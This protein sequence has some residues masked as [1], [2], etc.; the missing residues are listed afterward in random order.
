MDKENWIGLTV[1]EVMKQCKCRPQDISYIDDPPG[2]L[3]AV[4][5]T[6]ADGQ[7]KVL[8]IVYHAGLFSAQRNWS[9]TV[10][11]EQKVIKVLTDTELLF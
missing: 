1:A 4:E 11:G 3:R 6:D 2:K 10:V 8:E 7:K 9:F 5:I